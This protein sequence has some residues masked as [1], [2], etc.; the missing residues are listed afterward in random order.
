MYL[1]LYIIIGL[2][3][4]HN[5][6][7]ASNIACQNLFLFS[8]EKLNITYKTAVKKGPDGKP[9]SNLWILP[10][11]ENIDIDT[12]EFPITIPTVDTQKMNDSLLHRQRIK[13]LV[14]G[15][16]T[17]LG[18]RENWLYFLSE[19]FLRILEGIAKD[20]KDKLTTDTLQFIFALLQ[21]H[22]D[23]LELSV[24]DN[25][26]EFNLPNGQSRIAKTSG[27]IGEPIVFNGQVIHSIKVTA[28]P[29]NPTDN[30]P[31]PISVDKT[32]FLELHFSTQEE[33]Q[34]TLGNQAAADTL[35]SLFAILVHEAGH[36]LKI[37]DGPNNLLDK[38]A[39]EISNL[40]RDQI[41]EVDLNLTNHPWIKA[42]NFSFDKSKSSSRLLLF[43]T[44]FIHDIT[45]SVIAKAKADTKLDFSN[46]SFV[47]LHWEASH[48]ADL[49][50]YTSPNV[51]SFDIL[52]DTSTGQKLIRTRVVNYFGPSVNGQLLRD[53]NPSAPWENSLIGLKT[54][55]TFLRTETQIL[56]DKVV[57]I[58]NPAKEYI[59]ESIY[60]QSKVIKAGEKLKTSILIPIEINDSPT[61]AI[62]YLSKKGSVNSGFIKI[63]R[64]PF[65]RTRIEH[66]GTD[67]A[68][69][70]SEFDIPN[71]MQSGEYFVSKVFVK[72]RSGKTQEFQPNVLDLIEIQGSQMKASL[73]M[74]GTELALMESP[75]RPG[76]KPRQL[77]RAEAFDNLPYGGILPLIF[78][79]ENVSIPQRISLHGFV[80]FKEIGKE[81]NVSGLHLNILGPNKS[82]LIGDVSITKS[83]NK[84]QVVVQFHMP[85]RLNHKKVEAYYIDS[86]YLQD[87]NMTEVFEPS[88]FG[89]GIDV[90]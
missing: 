74:Y 65:T 55:Q 30:F 77:V 44:T 49:Y 59:T 34:N 52:V 20:H 63:A 50:H 15:G 39:A 75:K 43:D 67:K 73:D 80:E 64:V 23:G 60:H 76:P 19:N 28:N 32:P 26:S 17:G 62:V 85:K 61:E 88:T 57:D 90:K 10:G 79:F 66:L 5:E 35:R 42:I 33:A 54:E 81:R 56:L 6:T 2:L 78:N 12:T 40:F 11:K 14:R 9:I 71:K 82:P 36:Y 47:N 72:L 37:P 31:I 29:T 68:F 69:L 22:R 21:V 38:Y 13:S 84:T 1:Y 51:L 41:E 46:Y 4:S 87:E 24:S 89:M 3:L 86:I 48:T 70:H 7:H 45:N 53:V 83:G 16:F 25:S 8:V 58:N 27:K 18:V